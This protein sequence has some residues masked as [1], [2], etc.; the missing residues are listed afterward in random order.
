MS[1]YRGVGWA[2]NRLD[3]KFEI[4]VI[5]CPHILHATSVDC[6]YAYAIATRNV[7]RLPVYKY[8][9]AIATQATREFSC[10]GYKRAPFRAIM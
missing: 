6:P 1:E 3:F 8:T 2:V 7:C 10:S 9:H 5:F 4:A